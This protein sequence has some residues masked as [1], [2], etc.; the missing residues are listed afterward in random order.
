M[1]AAKGRYLEDFVIEMD[2]RNTNLE[3]AFSDMFSQNYITEAKP[4]NAMVGLTEVCNLNCAFCPYCGS[5]VKRTNK[6][7]KVLDA[8]TMQNFTKALGCEKFLNISLQGEPLL[9]PHF[10]KF[11]ELCRE[12]GA[13]SNM[14]LTTNGTQLNRIDASSLEGINLIAVSFDG[15]DKKTFEIL[16][17]GANYEMVLEN[18]DRIRKELPNAILQMCVVVCRLNLEQLADIFCLARKKGFNYITF[19]TVYGNEEDRVINLLRL[20]ESDRAELKKQLEKIKSLNEDEEIAV[21]DVTTFDGFEDGTERNYDYIYNE[22][23]RL[24]SKAPYLESF[25]EIDATGEDR[26]VKIEN[27]T[28]AG[29]SKR[30]PYCTAPWTTFA[31]APDAKVMPCCAG[32]GKIDS[33]E[34]REFQEIWNGQSFHKL[35][36]AMF[37]W[38]MLPDYCKKCKSFMRYDYIN[39]YYNFLKRRNVE[40]VEIPPHFFPNRELIKDDEFWECICSKNTTRANVESNIIM[41]VKNNTAM[42]PSSRTWDIVAEKYNIEIDDSDRE[43]SREIVKLLLA[44]GIEPGMK[45]LELGSGS[46]HLSACLAMQGYEVTLLDFSEKALEKSQQTFTYYGIDGE[47]IKADIFDL[48]EITESYDLIWNSGVMEHF[49]EEDFVEILQSVRRISDSSRFLFLVPNMKSRA[50]L[51]WRYNAHSRE[52]WDFGK[53]YVRRDY[54]ML[55][56]RAGFS[57]ESTSYCCCNNAVYMFGS[58]FDDAKNKEIYADMLSK[59]LFPEDE[60]YLVAYM[61]NAE[62]ERGA[63]SRSDSQ[64]DELVDY[65]YESNLEMN[66]QLFGAKRTLEQC[67]LKIAGVEKF[68][69]AKLEE[70][71]KCYKSALE[72]K[73]KCYKSALEEK[74]EKIS[75]LE[76]T[77]SNEKTYSQFL[78][79]TARL[80]LD[81]RLSLINADY[82]CVSQLLT[83]CN[84]L[85]GSRAFRLAHLLSRWKYQRNNSDLNERKAFWKWLR[86]RFIHKVPD[87]DHKYNPL[88]QIISPLRERERV[89]SDF[90]SA[91]KV[92]LIKCGQSDEKDSFDTSLQKESGIKHKCDCLSEEYKKYDVVILSVIDYD[93][94]YQRPQQIAD[95]FARKGHRVYYFNANFVSEGSTE[96]KSNGNLRVVT[97][98]NPQNATIYS[99]EREEHG[100]S[101]IYELEKLLIKDGIRDAALIVDYPNWYEAAKYLRDKYGFSLVTD[102]MDDFA[103]FKDT[104]N[105]YLAKECRKLLANSD[106]VVASSKYLTERA[107]EYNDKVITVRNGTEFKHFNSVCGEPSKGN[108]IGY[109]G[110][111]AHWF[112]YGKIEYLSKRFPDTDIVLI[113][114]VTAWEKE[115]KRMPNVRLLGEKSYAELPQYLKDFDV[116]LIPFDASTDLIQATNPVKFYEYLAAGKKIVAT[117]IPELEP[118]RDRLVYLAND[119]K[120]FGDYVEACLGG[121]DSLV[122]VQERIEFAKKNDWQVRVSEIEAATKTVFPLI[123]IVVLCYNQLDYTKQCVESILSNTAYPRYELVLVDNNSTDGTAEYLREIER[124]YGNV[125][126]VLNRTNRGFAGGNNDG[127]KVSKGDYLVLLN[128]D[129]IVTRGWLTNLVKRF[130]ES[131]VGLV[132]PVTNS[133]GNE[134]M[135]DLGYKKE[136]GKMPLAAYAYTSEHMG[137]NYPNSGVLAMFCLMFSRALLEK[138]GPLDE[139]YGVGMFEDDDYC[140]A[141]RKARYDIVL[142]EDV[143]VH[144]YGSVSFNKLEDETYRLL[145]EK[146]KAYFEGKWGQKWQPHKYRKDISRNN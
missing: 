6:A 120:K 26:R 48:P 121:K 34:R 47:F 131:K 46:G 86:T 123:S 3:R 127:I 80:E 144:H 15:A 4:I 145:F 95:F 60:Q 71:E 100:R 112:D 143:F 28:K 81:S 111:I 32:F 25:A 105:D 62:G 21:N 142:A 118:F 53:E 124:E 128:N 65:L 12:K 92:D 14:Q 101:F 22:L 16:R 75:L 125:R 5:C 10:G 63:F 104:A 66:A 78:D 29:K 126:I 108:C 72:E 45:L 1:R 140:T 8:D 79:D 116:C 134:A 73:E 91:A 55:C 7:P 40:A 129:T 106:V 94:R 115:L 107:K 69:K 19:N 35:R 109:Y 24:E 2:N 96:I 138:I 114:E 13:L 136:I 42:R 61:L 82:W 84:S 36:E 59:Q 51:M 44:H 49:S 54:K 43:L 90:L 99:V 117:E 141:A 67:K 30:I 133:I 83:T 18:I 9:Y 89:L 146:N 110:A 37:D 98:L 52:A 132:G 102:Y 88:Y 56:E 68:Y 137:E 64:T 103:G 135:V 97:L 70:Q 39:E 33:L 93:F 20:R 58:T 130:R 87:S 31:V 139:N 27:R 17:V 50:Y 11:I 38:D 85:L 23:L 74:E 57:V 41:D 77:L 119:N 113:G 122:S 76:K